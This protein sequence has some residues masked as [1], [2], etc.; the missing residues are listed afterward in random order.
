MA[1]DPPVTGG[2]PGERAAERRD[3]R[4]NRVTPS[5]PH[6]YSAAI[7]SN[8]RASGVAERLIENSRHELVY[9]W[10]VRLPGASDVKNRDSELLD[11]RS[12]LLRVIRLFVFFAEMNYWL[13]ILF[14]QLDGQERAASQFPQ[15]GE[16][17][18]R[19]R[20]TNIPLGPLR[21][22]IRRCFNQI[23]KMINC[24]V[25]GLAAF[26]TP[27]SLRYPALDRP[28][29]GGSISARLSTGNDLRHHP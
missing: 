11:E 20:V 26:R 25:F 21:I 19:I 29:E 27:A 28:I 22:I 9:A 17:R 6:H 14:S 1:R 18:R 4:V 12:Q 7:L 2:P 5:V 13:V 10:F 23:V 8:V 16:D 15:N 24:S 3:D